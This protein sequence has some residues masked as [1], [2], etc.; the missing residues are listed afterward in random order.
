MEITE[1]TVYR[2]GTGELV[3]RIFEDGEVIKEI[4]SDE[5]EVDIKAKEEVKQCQER[6]HLER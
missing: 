3:T 6:D 4:T 2:K 5:Y 1:I